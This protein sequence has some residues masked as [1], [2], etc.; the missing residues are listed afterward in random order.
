M[1]LK[2]HL[3]FIKMGLQYKRT[4]Q[5]KGS[6]AAALGFNFNYVSAL[7][8][9]MSQHEIAQ[10]GGQ[11]NTARFVNKSA[12]DIVLSYSF[13]VEQSY[14]CTYCSKV[15]KVRHAFNVKDS[16][17]SVFLYDCR[18]LNSYKPLINHPNNDLH[19][20]LY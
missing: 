2:Q 15:F 20:K 18:R 11:C 17:E 13:D 16:M 6:N 4:Y 7:R 1:L 8:V 10:A 5:K 14:D 19:L 3:F 9:R 12:F